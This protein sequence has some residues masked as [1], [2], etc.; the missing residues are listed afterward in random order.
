MRIL[1]VLTQFALTGA[2]VYAATLANAQIAQGNEVFIVSPFWHSKVSAKV[3]KLPLG[4]GA[5][6]KRIKSV[7]MLRNLIK[8]LQID[9]VHAHSRA[10]SWVCYFATKGSGV[11]FISTVHGRQHLHKYKRNSDVYGARVIA[12]C[13][14]I[15]LHLVGE[16][17]M[18]AAKISVIPNGMN[19]PEL[20]TETESVLPQWN[21]VTLCIPGRTTGPKGDRTGLII[22]KILPSLF[23]KHPDFRVVIVGGDLTDLNLSFQQAWISL[24]SQY[25]QQCIWVGFVNNLKD[26]VASSQIV[27]GSGRVAIEA[28]AADIVT[29]SFGESCYN[30][31]VNT[32]TISE[33]MASNFGDI[34]P[35]MPLPV[36][37]WEKV[38]SDIELAITVKLG[39][40]VR[41][42]VL[43]A[44]S[45][46][47][48]LDQVNGVYQEVLRK[49]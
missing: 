5:I 21:G 16:M 49:R 48:V 3:V 40:E 11:P 29:L 24:A 43:A 15:K 12:V 25:P 8:R 44:Y 34:S 6:S 37:D 27:I 20:L 19:F 32:N 45:L 22:S 26:Y 23:Q 7:F 18:N 28:I 14:N 36:V 2:E 1:H 38:A 47:T 4:Y 13:E 30:G 31:I 35:S 17:G 10:S 9:V 46:P 33:A 41:N 39:V 42:Q